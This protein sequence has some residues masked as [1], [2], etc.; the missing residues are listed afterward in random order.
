[1]IR[2]FV[3]TD[4]YLIHL[5]PLFGC[6]DAPLPVVPIRSHLRCLFVDLVCYVAFDLLGVFPLRFDLPVFTL[7]YIFPDLAHSSPLHDLICCYILYEPHLHLL[8]VPALRLRL[9]LHSS[10]FLIYVIQL[11]FIFWAIRCCCCYDCRALRDLLIWSM[12]R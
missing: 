7:F 11:R 10:L 4:W 1:M 2:F 8:L 12:E 3:T 9:I 5:L 6:S